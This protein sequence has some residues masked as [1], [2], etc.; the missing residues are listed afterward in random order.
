MMFQDMKTIE[1]LYTYLYNL[2]Y[3]T[4]IQTS[5]M[6][7]IAYQAFDD[8]IAVIVSSIQFECGLSHFMCAAS[9]PG[10][11]RANSARAFALPEPK[12]TESFN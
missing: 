1:N 5:T 10:L 11:R 4:V 6:D 9:T 2:I 7:I 8:Q 3:Y 12:E